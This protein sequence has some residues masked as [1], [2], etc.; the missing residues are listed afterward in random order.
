LAPIENLRSVF[1]AVLAVPVEDND[2]VL[3]FVSRRLQL[4]KLPDFL[5]ARALELEIRLGLAFSRF[6]ERLHAGHLLGLEDPVAT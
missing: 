2:N 1:S 6:L 4:L 3:L 5:Q